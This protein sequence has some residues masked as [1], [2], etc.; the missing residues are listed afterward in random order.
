MRKNAVRCISTGEEKNHERCRPLML[1]AAAVL[2]RNAESSLRGRMGK[3][4][5]SV[6]V[7]DSFKYDEDHK[8]SATLIIKFARE[9]LF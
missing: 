6:H 8:V 3:L 9:F 4:E 2:I 7:Y 5:S 1:A